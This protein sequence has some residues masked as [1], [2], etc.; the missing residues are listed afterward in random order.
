MTAPIPHTMAPVPR[1]FAAT[2][3]AD[4]PGAAAPGP[5]EGFPVR[6]PGAASPPDARGFPLPLA[7]AP[8]SPGTA[9]GAIPDGDE[10]RGPG[11]T[12]LTG[13]P[14]RAF[15]ARSPEAVE[16]LALGGGDLV[17]GSRFA[18]LL[19]GGGGGDLLRG[20]AGDDTLLGGAGNDTLLGGAGADVLEGGA[21]RD[22]LA[23]GAGADVF[24]FRAP[25]DA[26]RAFLV[27][28]ADAAGLGPDV[29]ADFSLAEGDKIDLSAI[30]DADSSAA[31]GRGFFFVGDVTDLIR[32]A[33]YAPGEV[34]YVRSGGDTF[35][36]VN[37]GLLGFTVQLSGLVD[38][39]E[40]DFIL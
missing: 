27:P 26:G 15:F 28:G 5:A 7:P 33:V 31:G 34:S 38:L 29:V 25:D 39:A 4:A 19:D 21:G 6:V 1:R 16:V 18:D 24:R 9:P 8:I 23:G 11:G 3:E 13:G 10:A 30:R 32:P 35:V 40:G 22:V 12:V 20:R 14:D 37:A 36:T 17:A 2:S